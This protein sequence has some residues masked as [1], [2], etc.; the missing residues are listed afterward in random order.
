VPALWQPQDDKLSLWAHTDDVFMSTILNAHENDGDGDGDGGMACF[1]SDSAAIMH[2]HSPPPFDAAL[3][4]HTYVTYTTKLIRPRAIPPCNPP[5]AT[6][7]AKTKSAAVA[8]KTAL[9]KRVPRARAKSAKPPPRD[10]VDTYSINCAEKLIREGC[11]GA[12]KC[13]CMGLAVQCFGIF[14]YKPEALTNVC[15]FF[16]H[17]C[18]FVSDKKYKI[19]RHYRGTHLR[20]NAPMVSK[21]RFKLVSTTPPQ[22]QPNTSSI[23]SSR[24]PPSYA[25]TASIASSR[26]PQS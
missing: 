18:D 1:R 6:H 25:K 14:M 20:G 13:P 19:M 9:C 11:V 16:C 23:A 7:A 22:S 5:A 15:Y 2:A 10:V 4:T 21:R 17:S 24:A 12:A 26:V 8:T 3:G